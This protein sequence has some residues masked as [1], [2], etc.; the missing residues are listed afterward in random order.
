MTRRL[1]GETEGVYGQVRS[2]LEIVPGSATA[3]GGVR[4]WQLVTRLSKSPRDR[5]ILV[6]VEFRQLK[7]FLAVLDT[8]SVTRAAAKVNL[9]P[10][11]VSLQLQSL[12]AEL[13]TDLFVRCGRCLAPTPAALRLAEHA[14][15]M[16]VLM[17]QM[18]Q[19]FENDPVDG[20][21]FHLATG[22]TTLIHRLGRPLRLLRKRFPDTSIEITVSTTE[23]MA[24]GLHSRRFDLA[25]VSLPFSDT[26]LEY[27]PLFEEELLLLKPAARSVSGWHVGSID[28]EELQ[29]APFLL[30]PSRSNMR[31]MID[32]F[33]AEA[34]ITPRIVMEADETEAIK[35][36]V[37]SGFGYS[38]LPASALRTQPRFF[39]VYR[40]AGRKLTRTQALATARTE[41]PRALTAAIAEF[42]RQALAGNQSADPAQAQ[43]A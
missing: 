8:S 9:T 22:A 28:V 3:P 15:P 17:R 31:R 18:E 1:K 39:Q 7:L 13:R 6:T 16:L 25:I 20:R 11:A 40:I 26:G 38:M 36:L 41:H 30:Y 35:K 2:A 34:G 37:E 32:A 42:L 23:D 19:E 43:R 33:L 21:P 10:G 27:T 14:R 12:A 24:A 29:S 5:D 4:G